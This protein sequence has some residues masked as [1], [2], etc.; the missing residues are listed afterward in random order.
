MAKKAPG[1]VYE[2]M[3]F[4][5]LM[6][7]DAQQVFFAEEF[8][9]LGT[10]K[11]F[12][13]GS[14]VLNVPFIANIANSDSSQNY[15]VA[16]LATISIPAASLPAAPQRHDTLTFGSVVYTFTTRI[17]ADKDVYTYAVET[18]ERHNPK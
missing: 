15:G 1:K 6:S 11:S 17:N 4:K 18:E 10:F 2:L 9:D 7:I 12:T 8:A 5:D 3:N 13:T 16:D 14:T